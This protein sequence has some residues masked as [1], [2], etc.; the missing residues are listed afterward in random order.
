VVK[1]LILLDGQAE[2]VPGFNDTAEDGKRTLRG[3]FDVDEAEAFFL[4]HISQSDL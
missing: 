4:R 1:G 3:D 2:C